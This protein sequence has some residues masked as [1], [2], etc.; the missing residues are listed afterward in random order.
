[1]KA[2]ALTLIRSLRASHPHCDVLVISVFGDAETVID[3]VE[4]GAVGYIH[5]DSQP[6]DVARSSWKSGTGPRRS[7]R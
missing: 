7:R 6:G 3:C 4:A 5:K 1:M 2:A